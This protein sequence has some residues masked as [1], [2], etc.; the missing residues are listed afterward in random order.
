MKRTHSILTLMMLTLLCCRSDAPS[1]DKWNIQLFA[2]SARSQLQENILP[3][4]LAHSVDTRHGG[5]Y[6]R[7]TTDGTGIEDAPKGL[8]LNARILW[9]FSAAYRYLPIFPKE[10]ELNPITE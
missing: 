5:F 2:Q 1:G 6:G 8:V 7:I 10:R 4:W 9:T 3:F